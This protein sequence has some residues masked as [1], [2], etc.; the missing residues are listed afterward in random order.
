MHSHITISRH[1]SKLFNSIDRENRC[2]GWLRNQRRSQANWHVNWLVAQ[3]YN[4]VLAFGR[5]TSVSLSLSPSVFLSYATFQ[6]PHS[7]AS[8]TPLRRTSLIH[9]ARTRSL[10]PSHAYQ[11]VTNLRSSSFVVAVA[12]TTT[13]TSIRSFGAYVIMTEPHY[14]CLGVVVGWY[15]RVLLVELARMVE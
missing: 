15:C 12:T 11:P 14:A 10:T 8:K 4:L 7:D 2:G 13:T 9:V 3:F 1:F 5:P 6:P